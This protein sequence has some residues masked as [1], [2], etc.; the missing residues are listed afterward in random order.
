MR[1][2]VVPSAW[3]LVQIKIRKTLAFVKA[4]EFPKN[5][6][7]H[8][9]LSWTC[10]AYKC[11]NGRPHLQRNARFQKQVFAFAFEIQQRESPKSWDCCCFL[12]HSCFGEDGRF[13]R[14]RERWQQPILP[15]WAWGQG[16]VGVG[17]RSLSRRGKGCSFL[18]W[19]QLEA[20]L[21]TAGAFI[22]LQLE[23]SC[24]Q[25]ELFCWP[26]TPFYLQWESTSHKQLNELRAKK[27]NCTPAE[28]IT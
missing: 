21:L 2:R 27:L 17:F 6:L 14:T 8:L 13:L 24:L 11:S 15:V 12:A 25:L 18:F 1:I 5:I 10:W 22:R 20:S 9:L 4:N 3:K 16:R 26:W 23:L 7:S 28:M 19:L